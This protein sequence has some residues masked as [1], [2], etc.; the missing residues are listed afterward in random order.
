MD[1]ASYLHLKT[2]LVHL[3]IKPSNILVYDDETLK[4]TDF[5]LCEMIND[6]SINKT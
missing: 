4:I 3:D 2:Y 5:G 1:G 6:S